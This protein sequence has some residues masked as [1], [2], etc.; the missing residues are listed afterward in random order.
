MTEDQAVCHKE[1][2][3]E[4][5]LDGHNL[6]TILGNLLDRRQDS[7]AARSLICVSL[8][9]TNLFVEEKDEETSRIVFADHR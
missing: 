6:H 7:R 5:K 4:N 9:I 3:L 2:R 8:P 1:G